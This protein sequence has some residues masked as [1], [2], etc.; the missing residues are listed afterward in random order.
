MS[1]CPHCEGKFVFKSTN[2]T[3][4]SIEKTFECSDCGFVKITDIPQKRNIKLTKMKN[5]FD[6]ILEFDDDSITELE[7]D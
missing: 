6:D 7:F 3:Q 5:I 1:S 2:S 4:T